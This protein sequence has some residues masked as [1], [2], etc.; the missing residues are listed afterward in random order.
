ML[1]GDVNNDGILNEADVELLNSAVRKLIIFKPDQEA[2]GDFDNNGKITRNDVNTLRAFL[3]KTVKGDANRDGK[4][5]VDDAK[6]IMDEIT[7]RLHLSGKNFENADLNGDRK[8]DI[9]DLLLLL[10]LLEGIIIPKNKVVIRLDS[11]EKGECLS[12]F[13]ATQ[14]S[15]RI[16][17]TLKDDTN[18]YFKWTDKDNSARTAVEAVGNK[19][20]AGSNLVLEISIPQSSGIKTIPSMVDIITETGRVVGHNFCCSGEDW[21]DDDYN[22]FYVNVIGWK[23][24]V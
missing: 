21:K 4:L 19:I 5:T 14:A 17:V 10:Q 23:S 20:Y 24:K 3:T 16:T 1:K 18:E 15:N 2:A 22:D 9:D 12:C 7:C 8:I 11:F 13:V 6:V